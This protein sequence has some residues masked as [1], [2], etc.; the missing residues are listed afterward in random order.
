MQTLKKML[1]YWAIAIVGF[2]ALPFVIRDLGTALLILFIALPALCFV[3]AL[4]Y[5]IKNGLNIIFPIVIAILFV[6]SIFLHYNSTAWVYTIA[7]FI[8]AFVGNL[9][10]KVFYHK[11]KEIEQIDAQDLEK[12]QRIHSPID[13]NL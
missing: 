5:G 3:C 7:Y 4:V 8:I 11:N 13:S 10:G 2:Y 12:T 6:P 9:I 1:P